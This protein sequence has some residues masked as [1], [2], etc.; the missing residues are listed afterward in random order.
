MNTDPVVRGWGSAGAISG[1]PQL[2][3]SAEVNGRA[4]GERVDHFGA[5]A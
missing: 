3:R 4:L 2:K 5:P 1:P